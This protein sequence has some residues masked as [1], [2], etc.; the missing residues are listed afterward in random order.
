MTVR[1]ASLAMSARADE[2]AARAASRHV[3]AAI[4]GTISGMRV[5]LS[6]AGSDPTGGAGLQAD[7][8]VFRT[9]GVHGAGVVTALT[10]QDSSKVHEVLPVFPNVVLAQLRRLFEDFT[11]DAI[12]IGM[13]AS[14][15]VARM[16]ELGLRSSGDAPGTRPPIVL[17]PVL[18]ASDGTRLV[19][20]RALAAVQD[21]VGVTTLVTP[22]LSEAQAL[23][24]CD[25]STE[26]GSQLAASAL[27][28]NLGAMAALVKGG[29]RDGPPHDLFAEREGGSV[30]FTWL[31]GERIAGDPVHGTG[32]A[33]ASAVT[34]ELAKGARLRDA[35]DSGRRF[36]ADA[37]RRAERLGKRA[38][39]LVYD[40]DD[41]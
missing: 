28:M 34:A 25:V 21:L 36:V 41:G 15:D 26:E 22:N 39:F 38:R 12:K 19:E 11:P 3:N 2:I 7:L 35:V 31:D 1:G 20:R 37:I 27:V 16:V 6:I 40:A 13:L 24:G 4:R 23:T 17:D 9:L 14:D 30:S 33:L 32:C 29:H 8:Q 10:V 5:A 18:E